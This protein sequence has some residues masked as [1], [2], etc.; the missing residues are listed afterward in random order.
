MGGRR[1]ASR[2]GPDQANAAGTP[3]TCP[4]GS[5][6]FGNPALLVQFSLKFAPAPGVNS[7]L[8]Q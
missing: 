1:Q 6:G 7:Y 8:V 3:A 2:V 5:I 4:G